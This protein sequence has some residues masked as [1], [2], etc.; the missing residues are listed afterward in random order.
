VSEAGERVLLLVGSP[1]GLEKSSSARLGRFVV[2]RLRQYGWTSKAIHL[3]EAMRSEEGRDD[4]LGEVDRAAVILF[5]APLYVDSLPAPAIRALESIAAHRATAA[6]DR[7]PRFIPLLNCGFLEPSQNDM[8]QELLRRFA[9]TAR[10]DGGTGISLGGAGALTKRVRGAL[11]QLVEAIHLELLVPDDALEST[12][13]PLMPRWLY[14][15]GGN[16]M[17]RRT[18]AKNGVKE[19]LRDRPYASG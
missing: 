14:I 19:R 5:A 17:W 15:L 6:N 4:L 12:R 2:D 8:C 11:E 13:K 3:H 1:K 9:E 16:A 10:F 7:R 18:A